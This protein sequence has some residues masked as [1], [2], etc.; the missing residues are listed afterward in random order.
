MKLNYSYKESN[1]AFCVPRN[2]HKSFI[3]YRNIL[4]ITSYIKLYKELEMYKK[5]NL[6]KENEK[7]EENVDK[8]KKG[9][10]HSSLRIRNYLYY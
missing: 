5:M 6:E 7:Y 9:N 3:Y 2:F 10:R 1:L 8:I 4:D